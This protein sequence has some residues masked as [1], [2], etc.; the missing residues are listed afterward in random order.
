MKDIGVTPLSFAHVKLALEKLARYHAASIHINW[1][2]ILP[3]LQKDVMFESSHCP[4]PTLLRKACEGYSKLITHFHPNVS[5]KYAEWLLNTQKTNEIMLSMVKPNIIF[6]NVLGHGDFWLNNMMFYENESTGKPEDVIFIDF[7]MCRYVPASRDIQNFLYTCFGK[8]F[9]DEY[10]PQLLA[11]Y[12]SS[13][14]QALGREYLTVEVFEREYEE[15]R[16]FGV[17][18]A[19]VFRSMNLMPDLYPGPGEVL[20]S[21]LFEGI[22]SG[23]Q[24]DT[25]IDR[26]QRDEIFREAAYALTEEL[27][28]V[29]DKR[30][31]V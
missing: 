13:F 21:D 23:R 31:M 24:F 11:A 9:R 12:V 5:H 15:C 26:C 16:L 25:L 1:H 17:L 8:K 18:I 7:Q 2:Q 6:T 10:E 29:L 20:T 27:M 19:F 22:M 3:Y 30:C 28:V 14:N 4:F